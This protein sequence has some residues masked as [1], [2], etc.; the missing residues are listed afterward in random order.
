MQKQRLQWTPGGT[1]VQES[2]SCGLCNYLPSSTT[3]ILYGDLLHLQLSTATLHLG[4]ST[5]H[6]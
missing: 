6:Y 5:D 3:N 2:K 1:E 4:L